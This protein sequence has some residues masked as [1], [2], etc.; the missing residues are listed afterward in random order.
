M[1]V[2]IKYTDS[3][4]EKNFVKYPF[5]SEKN[6]C[7]IGL[8]YDGTYSTKKATFFRKKETSLGK[9]CVYGMFILYMLCAYVY[10]YSMYVYHPRRLKKL[11]NQKNLWLLRE[12]RNN[13]SSFFAK[14][15]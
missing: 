14:S 10:V 8:R 2:N 4:F 5:N 11:L 13:R 15:I 3:L 12:G 1:K 9:R 6:W 7:E